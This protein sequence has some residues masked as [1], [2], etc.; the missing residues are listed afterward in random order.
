MKNKRNFTWQVYKWS[1][2]LGLVSSLYLHPIS[3]SGSWCFWFDFFSFRSLE[4]KTEYLNLIVMLIFISFLSG[5]EVGISLYFEGLNPRVGKYKW[6]V[7][8]ISTNCIR[9]EVTLSSGNW[10]LREVIGLTG[11]RRNYWQGTDRP[12]WQTGWWKHWFKK[13]ERKETTA[14]GQLFP[15]RKTLDLWC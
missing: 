1:H 3:Y 9:S 2:F 14:R 7:Q 11:N 10:L 8:M 15:N 6:Q 4:L 13:P 12:L 5:N